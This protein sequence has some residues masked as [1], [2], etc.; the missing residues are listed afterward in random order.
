MSELL[1]LGA[2]YKTARVAVRERIALTEAARGAP[3]G[4]A[5]ARA[6]DLRGRRAL[7]LQPHRA[8]PRG[9][10][11]GRG[12]ERRA[13]RSWRGA[14]ACG[15]P[16]SSRASTRCATAT[17]RGTSIASTSGLESMVVGEAEVQGQVKRAYEAAL[18]AQSTGPL[19]NKLFR[20]ALATGKRVRTDTAISVGRA[21]GRLRRR[22]R[23]ARRARRP[24]RPPRADHRRGRDRGADRAGA[25]RPGRQDDVRRQ[26]AARAG[27]RAGAAL[28]RRDGRVRRAARGAREGRHRRRL[29]LLAAPD[30]RRRG[31]RPR[32]PGAGRAAAAADRP[33]GAARHRPR[34]RRAPRRD[35]VRRRRPA[36]P[37]WRA[38]SSCA[39]P[40]RA[41][42]RASSRRRS[43][44]SRAGSARSR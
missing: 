18:S 37:R 31:A 11:R 14:P 15:R 2:S 41:R 10:R 30:P 6:D 23:R 36:A 32:R 9:R 7:H 13:R 42:P 29:D 17:P 27:D 28:R 24:R 26:P 34:V 35:A 1:A 44:P 19:T 33:R 40:R 21:L 3:H 25:A 22:R 39:A 8:L 12:R 4:R 5:R 20:A 43:R 38:T 16:S